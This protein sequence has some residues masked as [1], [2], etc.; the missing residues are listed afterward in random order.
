MPSASW[1]KNTPVIEQVK[2]NPQQYSFVQL[3]RLLEYS[4]TRQYSNTEYEDAVKFANQ[5]IA[6]YSPPQRECIRFF[7]NNNLAFAETEIK[8][9]EVP[10]E[11]IEIKQWHVY[12]AFLGLHGA[13]GVL[14]WHYSQLVLNR[15]KQ[16]DPTLEHFFNLFNHRTLSLFFQASVKYNPPIE[17]ER[18]GFTADGSIGQDCFTQILRSLIGL[19]TR[20]LERGLSVPD[21]ALLF[22]SGLF[23]Q[24]VRSSSGLQKIISSYFNVNVRIEE[25]LGRWQ[26]LIDDVRSRLPDQDNP[27]GQNVRLGR[28]AMLGKRGWFAQGKIR[29]VLGPVNIDQFK[30]FAPGTTALKS[31][32]D[33]VRFYVGIENDYDFKILIDW[34]SVPDKVRLGKDDPPIMGWNTWLS[35]P[36]GLEG[37]KKS[38]MMVSISSAAINAL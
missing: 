11:N 2:S 19:G 3:V 27:K 23:S 35:K 36:K 14:P 30:A 17:F 34:D 4:C 33:L 38:M 15:I 1:R 21:E 24:Q 7:H 8:R 6:R 26:D 16:K 22:Y 32:N 29:I 20:G 25:F 31:L 9:I 5:S 13:Q 12:T 37:Y 10:L 18:R 28:N